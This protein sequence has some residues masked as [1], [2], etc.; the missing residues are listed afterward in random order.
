LVRNAAAFD[1]KFGDR[2]L[3]RGANCNGTM[4]RPRFQGNLR[5][6]ETTLRSFREASRDV[7]RLLRKS[8]RAINHPITPVPRSRKHGSG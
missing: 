5:L 7:T 4:A 1:G 2:R 6:S 8:R 3:G